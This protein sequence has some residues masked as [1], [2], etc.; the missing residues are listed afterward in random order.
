MPSASRDEIL[1]VIMQTLVG[2]RVWRM[3]GGR[4][5]LQPGAAEIV[6]EASES[7]LDALGRLDLPDPALEDLLWGLYD[8]HDLTPEHASRDLDALRLTLTPEARR[9]D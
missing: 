9:V 3:L 1:Q 2:L 7:A 5:G 4:P 6:R 8:V